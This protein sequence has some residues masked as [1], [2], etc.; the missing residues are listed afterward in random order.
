[1]GACAAIQIEGVT[2]NRFSC[3]Q[4]AAN[5]QLN[6][7]IVGDNGSASDASGANTVNWDFDEASGVLTIQA[8]KTPYPCFLVKQRLESF[9][10]S[11]P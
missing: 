3:L 4:Q 10:E 11:C 8:T 5:Q 2:R 1:M 7:Q 6:V 9:L